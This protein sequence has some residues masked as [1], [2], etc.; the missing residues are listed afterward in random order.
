MD[1]T[2]YCGFRN[3]KLGVQ[4][5]GAFTYRTFFMNYFNSDLAEF[6]DLTAQS[7]VA[8]EFDTQ[9]ASP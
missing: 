3:P 4:V 8:E 9:A 1:S 2:K 6:T 5:G 7:N